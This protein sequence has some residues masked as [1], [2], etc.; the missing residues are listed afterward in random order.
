LGHPV[1]VLYYFVGH[2][3]TGLKTTATRDCYTIVQEKDM[4]ARV[5]LYSLP[6]FRATTSLNVAMN[7]LSFRVSTVQYTN[8]S[9]YVYLLLNSSLNTSIVG[10]R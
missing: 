9:A 1:Y 8:S 4:S 6:K 2:R 3:G 7:P 5:G 10:A